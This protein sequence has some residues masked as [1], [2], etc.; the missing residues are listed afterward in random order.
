MRKI[1]AVILV[2]VFVTGCVGEVITR[3][4]DV[5]S[6]ILHFDEHKLDM[7]YSII[8]DA[9]TDVYYLI[10]TDIYGGGMTVLLNP[11]GTPRLWK[12][13]ENESK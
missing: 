7:E 9:D 10:N 12:V 3:E 5:A 6:Q 11:D 13:I 2:A 4:E 8:V 1:I